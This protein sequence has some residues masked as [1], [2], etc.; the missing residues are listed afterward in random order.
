MSNLVAAC[1]HPTAAVFLFLLCQRGSER[2]RMSSLPLNYGFNAQYI[3][4]PVA[5]VEGVT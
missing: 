5:P 2:S 4:S 3:S 1:S